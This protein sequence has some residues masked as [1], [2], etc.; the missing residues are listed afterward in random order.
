MKYWAVYKCPLCGK[1]SRLS[2]S[3]E[4]PYD[5]LPK[6][7]GKVIQNQSF[8]NNPYL[9]QAPMHIPCKCNDGNAGLAQFAGF[10]KDTS[11]TDKK[12]VDF[13]NKLIGK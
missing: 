12:A 13:L 1:L 6:I 3:V 10:V 11:T 2:D 8:I 9:Y 4:I 5:E 7:L